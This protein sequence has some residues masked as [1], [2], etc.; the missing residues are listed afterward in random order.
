MKCQ[1]ILSVYLHNDII[2]IHIGNDNILLNYVYRGSEIIYN[3]GE[4]ILLYN[5][6][7]SGD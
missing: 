3:I 7:W 6:S 2:Y 4:N 1:S 5:N